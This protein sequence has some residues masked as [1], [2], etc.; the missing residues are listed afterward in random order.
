M[1]DWSLIGFSFF[2]IGDNKPIL[3]AKIRYLIELEKKGGDYVFLYL[4][5]LEVVLSVN[6]SKGSPLCLK[7]FVIE[8][9]TCF[10]QYLP[11]FLEKVACFLQYLPCFLKKVAYF[12]NISLVYFEVYDKVQKGFHTN[13]RVHCLLQ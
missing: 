6:W 4:F 10:L 1:T 2:A 7:L 13:V 5:L 9:L 12:S 11:C 8:A 3:T